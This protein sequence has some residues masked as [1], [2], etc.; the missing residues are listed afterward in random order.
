MNDSYFM[1][2]TSFGKVAL[3][4]L[5]PVP[6]NFRIYE[7]G[8]LGSKPSEFTVMEVKGAEFRAAKSGPNKGELKIKIPN[9]NR[10]VY[11]TKEEIAAYN[12]TNKV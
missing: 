2:D 8:W 3:S 4:K 12:N 5:S 1:N 6:E 9:T 10:T 11:V 7:A